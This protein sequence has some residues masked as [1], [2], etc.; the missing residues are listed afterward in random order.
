VTL[1]SPCAAPPLF[2]LVQGAITGHEDPSSVTV[3]V[4]GGQLLLY[5]LTATTGRQAPSRSA[6][7][8][9]GAKLLTE[10]RSGSPSKRRTPAAA[11]QEQKQQQQQQQPESGP[12]PPVVQQLFKGQLQ[13][14]PL[15]TAARLRMIPIQPVPL[16]GLQVCGCGF[17][18]RQT[19]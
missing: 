17:V 9:A 4:E 11:Q 3:L 13:G 19:G 8:P 10:Q 18:C 15:V 14:K 1:F 16:R 5:D 2:V 12:P 6:S 7:P